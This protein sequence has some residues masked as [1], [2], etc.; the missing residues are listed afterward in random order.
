MRRVW[1]SILTIVLFL[2][3]VATAQSTPE[4][5]AGV[6]GYLPESED[7]GVLWRSTGPWT[8]TIVDQ[9]YAVRAAGVE[10]VG[11][12]G[13]RARVMII[14]HRQNRASIGQAWRTV[15]AWIDDTLS[16]REFDF[17]SSANGEP[18]A[19]NPPAGTVDAYRIAGY[20]T[21]YPLYVCTGAYAIDPDIRVY[22]RLE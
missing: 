17:S 20:M 2:P 12:L 11:D 10:F 13:Q 14:R 16:N 18:D 15:T 19:E 9:D 1:L 22:V 3:S 8:P 7:F 4:A 6:G 5:P 21:Y